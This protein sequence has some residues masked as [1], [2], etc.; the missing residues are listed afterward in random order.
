MRLEQIKRSE[1][2]IAITYD[3]SMNM[4]TYGNDNLYPQTIKLL[5]GG[6][7]IASICN[8]RYSKAIRG[9]GFE[10]KDLN[11]LVINKKGD[12]L[13][14]LLR[15]FAKDYAT[16]NGIAL[17]FK[18]NLNAEIEEITYIPFEQCRL[19]ENDDKG[20]VPF[21]LR[22]IDWS[23]KKTS[24][25]R[26]LEV[27]D[28]NVER[29]YTFNPKKKV[30]QAQILKDGGIEKY[31]GQIL[32][33][34]NEGLNR[35]P[36]PMSDPIRLEMSTDEGLSN[37]SYRNTRNSFLPAT[38]IML[39]EQQFADFTNH[40]YTGTD[41]VKKKEEKEY[42]LKEKRNKASQTILNLQG[43]ENTGK[44]GVLYY[45]SI[46]S[47]PETLNLDLKNYDKDFTVTEERVKSRIYGGYEQNIFNSIDNGKIGFSGQILQDAFEYYANQTEDERDFLT[48]TFEMIAKIHPELKDKDFTIEPPKYVSSKT[49]IE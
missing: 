36:I 49:N 22:M 1:E 29:Y 6:S 40:T 35:Y 37:V 44:I 15:F 10:D 17:H 20:Y 39:Q 28:T 27:N 5:I 48:E 18:Y 43:D 7:S 38:L 3:L 46:N 42:F 13:K 19:A 41:S 32:Y 11:A 12:T 30:I 45:D 9:K 33:I 34:G 14:Q 24:S 2:R 25:G 47:K 23:G 26:V 31:K 8:R 4:Q 21:I 16:F